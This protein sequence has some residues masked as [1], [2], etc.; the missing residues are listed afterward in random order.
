MSNNA[1]VWTDDRC[2]ELDNLG[3][4]LR[5][6]ASINSGSGCLERIARCID[7]AGSLLYEDLNRGRESFYH[8][9]RRLAIEDRTFNRTEMKGE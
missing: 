1:L 4:L 3:E 9:T 2:E 5:S 7:L 6:V 8:F